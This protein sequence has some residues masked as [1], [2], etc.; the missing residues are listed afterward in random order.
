MNSDTL[1]SDIF[2]EAMKSDS[3][4]NVSENTLNNKIHRG[5]IVAITEKDVFLDMGGKSEAVVPLEEFDETPVVGSYIDIVFKEVEEGIMVASKNEADKIKK[6]NEIKK[7]YK[8]DTGIK[9]TISE[10]VYKNNELKGFIVDLGYGINGFLP[11][12]QIDTRSKEPES[13]KGFS[14]DFSVIEFQK[15]NITL[16]RKRYLSRTI[17]KL[18][19]NF[20]H[21]HKV[22]D[23]LKAKVDRVEKDYMFLTA[24][25]VNLFMHISDFSWKFLQDLLKVVKEGDELE[26][27]I[28]V[29]DEAKKLIKVGRKQLLQDP[30]G[31]VAEKYSVSQLVKGKVV[32][33]KKNGALIEIEE[34]VE[35]FLPVEELSWT[36]KVKDPKNVLKHGDVVRVK[37]SSIEPENRK[38]V[39]SLRE[40]YENP[41][42]KARENYPVGKKVEG[43]I[44]SIV[45]FGLFIQ[46][47]DGIEGLMRREDVDWLD[48][49][50]NLK[51]KFKKGQKITVMVLSVEPE[52]ERLRLGYKQLSDNPYKTFSLNYPKGS[53]VNG[54]VKSISEEGVI[55]SLENNLE[56]FVPPNHLTKEKIDNPQ[57]K[58]EVGQEVKALVRFVDVNKSRIEL[59]IRDYL[60]NEEKIETEKY[61]ADSNQNLNQTTIGNILKDKLQNINLENK[62]AKGKNKAGK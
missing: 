22:G 54:K 9:G 34:G 48:P 27:A 15:N 38:M 28:L 51:T 58:F 23:V 61:L 11:L 16:S 7:A 31:S 13:L 33:F 59:S 21:N 49:N 18:Y 25:G 20:F 53:V 57:E 14:F 36:K 1:G 62:N 19:S 26:V 43:V 5:K 41:W 24:E 29:M 2:L 6:I 37:I 50:V 4:R 32:A 35:A 52:R 30:W 60:I 10:P 3:L 55:L 56:G 8:D 39:V 44:T 40:I 47:E 42:E 45:D 17:Q 46:F 12:S